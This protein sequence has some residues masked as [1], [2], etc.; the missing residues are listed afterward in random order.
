MT[1][2]LTTTT[3]S[4]SGGGAPSA[5]MIPYNNTISGLTATNVQSAIDELATELI[6]TVEL[7]D[8]LTVD[9]YA[10]YDLKIN[11]ITNIFNAPV[12]TIQD[13]GVAYVLT[14]TIIKG[15]KITV[16]ASVAGAVNLNIT[17]A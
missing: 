14:N 9:F 1:T 6:Y 16:T 2:T 4:I 13:D 12:I 10:P 3:M 5:S 17:K 15:S 7:V 8:A 11:T